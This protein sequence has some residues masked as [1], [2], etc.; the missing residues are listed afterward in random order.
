[1]IDEY[2]LTNCG[3]CGRHTDVA[4]GAVLANVA[5]IGCGHRGMLQWR[6]RLDS[7]PAEGRS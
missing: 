2:A 4:K 3:N 1:M 5:C 7:A 6:S